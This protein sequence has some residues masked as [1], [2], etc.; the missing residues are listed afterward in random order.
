M[1]LENTK[2]KL[3]FFSLVWF[4]LLVYLTVIFLFSAR[5]AI[6]V[7]H[8]KIIHTLVYGVLGFLSARGL[9]KSFPT[10][11][12]LFLYFIALLFGV[13]Y[14]ASDEWHQSFVPGR[15]CSGL[16]LLADTIGCTLGVTLYGFINFLFRQKPATW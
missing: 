12:K 10:K 11:N 3:R 1:I 4:P 6:A 15:D 2:C 9:E 16:D 7:G 5:P 8:D 14:G 13:L